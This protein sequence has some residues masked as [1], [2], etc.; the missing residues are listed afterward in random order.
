LARAISREQREIEADPLD[1]LASDPELDREAPHSPRR[2]D[3][4][5][6]SATLRALDADAAPVPV[7][8]ILVLKS[9][10]K[11]LRIGR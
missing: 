5:G 3:W 6:E 10:P 4:R 1:E 2:D 7:E 11:R 9:L 8:H